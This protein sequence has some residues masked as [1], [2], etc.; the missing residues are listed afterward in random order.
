V[1]NSTAGRRRAATPSEYDVPTREPRVKSTQAAKM[2]MA[3]V[4]AAWLLGVVMAGSSVV[5][6]DLPERAT[7]AGAVLLFVVFSVAL[8]HRVGGHMRIWAPMAA[9]LGLVAAITG[10]PVLVAAAAGASGVTAAVWAVVFTRP[11]LTVLQAIG[12]YLIAITIALSGTLCVAAWNASVNYARFNVVVI[13]AALGVS[14]IL[15]W[16]LGAG[17]HGLGKEHLII[18]SAIAALVVVILA[19]ASFVRSHGSE[20]ITDTIASMIIWMR[21]TVAGVPRPVEVFLGFPALIVGVSMRARTREGWWI[22]VFGVISTSVLTTSLVS[23]LAY[24]AYVG[25]S[26][27]YSAVLGLI[28]GLVV[29]RFVVPDNSRRATRVVEPERR[30]EPSRLAALK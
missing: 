29:R 23:P 6:Y 5:A 2:L 27:L 9:G 17:L 19:Y 20:L 28:I 25:L 24:P 26:T 13:A 7:T 18:L 3:G 11:A 16:N 12:E 10:N 15:V 14:I 22:M 4:G 30:I 8:T 1:T 21:Q